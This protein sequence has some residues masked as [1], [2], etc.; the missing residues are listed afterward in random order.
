MNDL[1]PPPRNPTTKSTTKHP[2]KIDHPSPASKDGGTISRSQFHTKRPNQQVEEGGEFVGVA[3]YCKQE[4]ERLGNGDGW[5]EA[6]DYRS[7]VRLVRRPEAAA[8]Q[9]PESPRAFRGRRLASSR[10]L[11]HI[12]FFSFLFFPNK[13]GKKE[14]GEMGIVLIHGPYRPNDNRPISRTA[15]Q[16][17]FYFQPIWNG[18]D[19]CVF[20]LLLLSCLLKLR[21]MLVKSILVIYLDANFAKTTLLP[22]EG[23]GN[24]FDFWTVALRGLYNIRFYS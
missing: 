8:R 12:F 9:P 1:S 13:E 18:M 24:L 5:S 21:D 7:E 20:Y 16:L 19:Y 17:K 23:N 10:L 3:D 2:K 4:P 6:R 15:R 14:S 11:Y 22:F